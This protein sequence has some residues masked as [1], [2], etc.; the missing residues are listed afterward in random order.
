MAISIGRATGPAEFASAGEMLE[1]IDHGV[2]PTINTSS[3]A[4]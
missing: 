2:A 4:V 3:Q 1:R